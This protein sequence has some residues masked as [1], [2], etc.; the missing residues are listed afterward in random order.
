MV[1]YFSI[2]SLDDYIQI[3]QRETNTDF[4]RSMNRI[5]FD[6]TVQENRE[7]FAYVTLPPSEEE[8]V[9]EKGN[10]EFE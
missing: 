3:L 8:I 10:L 6:K 4:C 2:L 7:T 5:V 1:Y 9:P